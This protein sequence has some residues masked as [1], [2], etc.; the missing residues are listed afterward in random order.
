MFKR[1]LVLL[2]IVIGFLFSAILVMA[3]A[4]PRKPSA[5]LEVG[6]SSS[7]TYHNIGA[8]IVAANPGDTIKVENNVFTETLS[9]T[10][11]LTII[12]GI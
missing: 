8:A 11:D 3:Q 12:G 1:L 4:P 7:C 9:I 5:I 10:K 6:T 2:L